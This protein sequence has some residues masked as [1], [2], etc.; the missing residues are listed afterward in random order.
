[1]SD[2][3]QP[4]DAYA[5]SNTIAKPTNGITAS[6]QPRHRTHL[7]F[8]D[9]LNIFACIAVVALHVSLNVFSPQPTHLWLKAVA[10]Q[11]MGIFAVPIFFMISGMNLLGYHE[12]YSTATFFKKRVLRTGRA[13]LLGS[14]ACY[15][16]FCLFPYSFYGANQFASGPNI[17][18]FAKRFLTNQIND[19]YWF[20]YT[21]IYL[22]IITPVISQAMNNKRIVQYILVI[23][24]FIAVLLP[25]LTHIGVPFKYFGTLFNWPLFAN[26]AMMYYVSG[27]YVKCYVDVQRIKPWVYALIFVLSTGVMI[28][29]GLISNG[30]HT[31]NGLHQQYDNYYIGTTSPL[32]VIQVLSLFL[33]VMSLEPLLQQRSNTVKKSIARISGLSLGVYLFHIL[34]INWWGVNYGTVLTN[35]P[36]MRLIIVYIVTAVG[37]FVGQTIIGWLKAITIHAVHFLRVSYQN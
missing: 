14:I 11:G 32:C 28:A 26:T 4:I 29:A 21:I 3:N 12:K 10:L 33:F 36:F 23:C 13:L 5:A 22:Y 2:V 6:S 16:L 31:S 7:I 20:F 34:V 19:I 18:D 1:M 9:V 30:W 17:V 8:V 37:V 35:N 15:A 25:F 27:Y 24:L